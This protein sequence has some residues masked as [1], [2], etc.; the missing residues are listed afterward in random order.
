MKLFYTFLILVVA[1][2]GCSKPLPEPTPAAQAAS[3]TPLPP[4]NT[5]TLKPT[6]TPTP[7]FT[8]TDTPTRTPTPTITL[9]PTPR[10][11][12]F[13]GGDGSVVTMISLNVVKLSL[14]DPSDFDLLADY[15]AIVQ[16]L[17][18]TKF[19]SLRNDAVSHEG[20]LVAFWNCATQY[21]DTE[22]GTLYLFSPNFKQKTSVEVPGYPVFMGWSAE[23]DRLLYYLGSTMADDY[24]II[25]TKDPGFGE[26]IKLGRLSDAAWSPDGQ[27]IYTQTGGKITEYDKD[28]KELHQHECNFNNAC[29]HALSPDGAHFA[30]IQRHV[31][32]SNS[33]AIVNITHPDFADKT[34]LRLKNDHAVILNVLWLPDSRHIVVIGESAKQYN[35]RFWRLDYLSVIDVETGEERVIELDIPE[36]SEGFSFCGMTPDGNNLVYTYTGGRVKQGGRLLLSGRYVMLLP[37]N[38]A[39]PEL[40]RLTEFDETWESCPA[41]VEP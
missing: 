23:H 4:T 18:I 14:K 6:N 34:S 41:W 36:D 37:L 29:M 8:P 16:N 40:V 5:P 32:S 15:D 1:L 30:A 3:A 38:D 2:C 9:T 10:A 21:C 13:G 7:T 35:R 11:T 25:K 39:D 24:Y 17:G 27:T 20:D 28:G 19:S 12:P 26:V 31:A 22:R 33:N